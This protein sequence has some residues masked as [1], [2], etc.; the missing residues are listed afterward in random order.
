MQDRHPWIRFS[1]AT[2]E[3]QGA[4]P[5]NDFA[6]THVTCSEC[7]KSFPVSAADVA[8]HTRVHGHI[9]PTALFVPTVDHGTHP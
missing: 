3:T 4:K 9:Q 6:G 2:P 7:G 1:P 5:L 8:E